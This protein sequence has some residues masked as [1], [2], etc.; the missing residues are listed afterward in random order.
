MVSPRRF[1]SLSRC[2]LL[3]GFRGVANSTKRVEECRE[4]AA[5]AQHGTQTRCQPATA[6]G[7]N[8]AGSVI[9]TNNHCPLEKST[10]QRKNMK[11]PTYCTFTALIRKSLIMNGAGEGNRT[12]ISGLG[13]PHSTT[14]PHPLSLRFSA[15]SP[16]SL[17]YHLPFSLAR[18]ARFVIEPVARPAFLLVSN[19]PPAGNRFAPAL[20]RGPQ[21][22]DG[23]T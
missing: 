15:A 22:V 14:E 17:C 12:L 13:S 7:E 5:R 19:L 11:E 6:G 10:T 20:R 9:N 16:P 23:L 3:A 18:R 1:S 4:S 8:F 2:R 21:T